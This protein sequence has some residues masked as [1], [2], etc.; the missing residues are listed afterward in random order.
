MTLPYEDGFMFHTIELGQMVDLNESLPTYAGGDWEILFHN[1]N[2]WTGCNGQFP[3]LPTC[4]TARREKRK[5]LSVNRIL[6]AMR[7][8]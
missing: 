5:Y 3:E 7:I 4:Q 6:F 1:I 2:Q 8:L